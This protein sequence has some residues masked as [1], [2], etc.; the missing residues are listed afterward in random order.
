M[1]KFLFAVLML[2]SPFVYSQAAD[3]EDNQERIAMVCFSRK[4]IVLRMAGLRDQGMTIEAYRKESPLPDSWTPAMKAEVT[5]VENYVWGH[6]TDE[7][8]GYADQIYSKCFDQLK[9]YFK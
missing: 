2:F 7:V 6:K 8:T 5:G 4:M 1:K 3:H 9:D